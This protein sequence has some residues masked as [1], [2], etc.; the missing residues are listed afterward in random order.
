MIRAD[1]AGTRRLSLITAQN[2]A[3]C[4][5]GGSQFTVA[6]GAYSD[7]APTCTTITSATTTS[8]DTAP[9]SGCINDYDFVNVKNTFSGSHTMTLQLTS[10]SG[11][12]FP[13]KTFAL[14]QDES[15]NYAHGTGFQF[16]DASGNLKESLAAATNWGVTG[17]LT[18]GGTGTFTGLV[19]LNGQ[20]NFSAHKNGT[21]Q[22]GIASGGFTKL[23][24]GTEIFDTG[25]YFASSTWTPPAGKVIVT[26]QIGCL[27]N[28][29]T[30][31]VFLATLYKNGARFKDGMSGLSSGIVSGDSTSTGS[32]IDSCNG[33]DIYEIYVFQNTGGNISVNGSSFST[34]FS[35]AQVA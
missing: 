20:A 2:G 7:L 15:M 22:T 33:T 5:V 6:T 9:A 16:F 35:G 14:L 29:P 30:N 12:P 18:V 32:V 34:Y 24:F 28:V 13:L 27:T 3:Q 4:V 19:A 25:N 11:G 31:T 10:G 23:T 17:N 26:W 1:N 8:I 21:N